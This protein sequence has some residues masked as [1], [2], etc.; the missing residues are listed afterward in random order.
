MLRVLSSSYA[1]PYPRRTSPT[2]AT[3]L[4]WAPPS[5]T[6]CVE[7][8]RR[9]GRGGYIDLTGLPNSPVGET[10][11]ASPS[12]WAPS[13]EAASSAATWRCSRVG[14]ALDG[15]LDK[16]RVAPAR[17]VHE[18]I[19]PS[20]ERALALNKAYRVTVA[21]QD[22]LCG[23]D[24]TTHAPANVFRHNRQRHGTHVAGVLGWMGHS[25][26]LVRNAATTDTGANSIDTP[27]S[28]VCDTYTM[29][30]HRPFAGL[31]TTVALAQARPEKPVRAHHPKT[32]AVGGPSCSERAASG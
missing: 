18:L 3:T 8:Q 6:P 13:A 31:P 2:W 11:E 22:Y 25:A 10:E 29:P 28:G 19:T 24:P 9:G 4:L 30:A 27:R 32:S 5:T 7:G 1:P 17:H 12:I 16:E 15:K 26:R 21:E 20:V 14:S 23:R